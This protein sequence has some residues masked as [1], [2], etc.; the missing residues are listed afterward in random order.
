MFLELAVM[1]W[2]RNIDQEKF[3]GTAK[4]NESGRSVEH[5]SALFTTRFCPAKSRKSWPGVAPALQEEAQ[6]ISGETSV[7]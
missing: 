1:L 4:V 2:I 7:H 3:P 5:V 6:E